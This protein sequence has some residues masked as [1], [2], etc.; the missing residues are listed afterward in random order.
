MKNAVITGST[1]GLG[2]AIANELAAMGYR[3]W[4]SARNAEELHQ[5]AS[6]INKEFQAEVDVQQ[7]DFTSEEAIENYAN[8]I[9]AECD[10][11]D[12]LVNNVGTYIP[13]AI[14]D[15][16]SFDV[17]MNLNFYAPFRL[18]QALLSTFQ[19]Q[20]RGHLFNICSVVNRKPRPEAAS[21]TISK[22]AFWGYHKL[23]HE[24]LKPLGVKVTAFFPGSINTA[25]WDGI[26]A[27]KDDFIQPEDIASMIRAILE[28]K[29]GTVASE[30]DLASINPEF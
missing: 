21:Y 30:I 2:R 24:T 17:Q 3:V 9:K 23:L 29:R 4:I 5:A 19:K 14:D 20:K 11:I 13:D 27:P 8:R 12:V 1:K 16:H 7:I 28:M 22:F 26:E 25:S 10:S 6:E 15:L 18:S